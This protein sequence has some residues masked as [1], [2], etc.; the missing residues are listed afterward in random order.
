MTS[1]EIAKE[2]ILTHCKRHNIDY[3]LFFKKWG[4][5]AVKV[6]NGIHIDW[7]KQSL[8]LYIKD[9]VDISNVK[10]AALLGYN[11]HTVVA[12]N[13]KKFRF[14]FQQNDDSIHERYADIAC[15]ADSL[16]DELSSAVV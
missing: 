9:N 7:H 3:Q 1:Q 8:S 10:L 6:Y 15:W 4:Q 2:I 12:Y 14:L 13:T 16:I 11:D 5:R